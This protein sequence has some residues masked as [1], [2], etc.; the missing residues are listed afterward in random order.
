MMIHRMLNSSVFA[1]VF[2]SQLGERVLLD[3]LWQYGT[4]WPCDPELRVSIQGF[5]EYQP[6]RGWS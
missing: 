1:S 5:L 3:L 4:D 6:Q 2:A